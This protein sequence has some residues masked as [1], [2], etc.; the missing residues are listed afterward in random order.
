MGFEIHV[1]APDEFDRWIANQQV[2]SPLINGGQ[3][4]ADTTRLADTAAQAARV[5]RDSLMAR[6]AQT[7]IAGGCIGCHAMVGTPM[8][9]QMGVIG[10]N[11][12]HVGSRAT[13]AGAMMA[14][15]DENL[16]RWLHDPQAV[17]PGT[18]MKLPRKLT[19]DEVQI[20]VAY[21]RAHQ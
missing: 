14:N 11:L 19:D 12:S 15:T 10:P 20:L 17:K 1:D 9:G 5:S 16:S 13:L 4:P 7:F 21:L 2:G 18:L 8:A 6:G 3:V